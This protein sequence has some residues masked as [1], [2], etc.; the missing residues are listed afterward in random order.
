MNYNYARDRRNGS[1]LIII[2]L[3]LAPLLWNSGLMA[4]TGQTVTW[5][6]GNTFKS[7]MGTTNWT[8]GVVPINDVSMIFTVIVPDTTS[9]R[10]DPPAPATI[11]AFSFGAG[12]QLMVTNGQLLEVTGVAVLK[13]VI[14]ATGTN[15]GFKASANTIVLSS[16]PRL[17]ANSGGAIQLGGSTY[18]WDKYNANATLIS[19]M[20]GGSVVDL[21]SLSSM[22]LSYGDG[23]AW[24][25]GITAKTNGLIDL[26][27]LANL[28]GPGSD[29]VLEVNADTGGQVKLGSVRQVGSNVRFN[30]GVPIFDLPEVTTISSATFNLKTGMVM[31]LPKLTAL[32]G[33][34]IDVDSNSTINANLATSISSSSISL[35]TGT[36]FQAPQLTTM[37]GVPLT[38]NGNAAFVAPN[39]TSYRNS[40]IPVNPARDLEV[41]ILTNIYGSAITVSGGST[42]TIGALDYAMPAFG[43][44]TYPPKPMLSATGAG[45]FLN[46]GSLKSIQ[47]AGANYVWDPDINNWRYDFT[48][49][50][51]ADSQGTIDLSGTE[52]VYGGDLSNYGGDD[53]LTF[54]ILNGGNILLP[55]LKR[56]LRHTSFDVRVPQY[57]LPSLETNEN[58]G[59]TLADGVK[60]DVPS[61]TRFDN[62]Y[63][64]FGFNSTFNAPKLR[65]YLNSD[66]NLAPGKIFLAP[67]FTNFNA[68]RVSVTS[69]STLGVAAE[70]YETPPDWRWSPTLFSADGSGSRLNFAS[71]K[72]LRVYGGD[73]GGWT[74]SVNANN[75]GVVDLSGLQTVTGPDFGSYGND[76]WLSFTAQNGGK[77]LLDSLR[78]INGH[79]RITLGDGQRQ[80]LPSLTRLANGVVFNLGAGSVLAAPQLSEV[81]NTSLTLGGAGD[82]Q[83]GTLTN[84]YS[85]QLAATGGRTLRVTAEAY[86]T[87]ATGNYSYPPRVLFS[88]D[89]SGSVLDAAAMRSIQVYGA[90]YS[91]DPMINNWRY[92]FTYSVFAKNGGLVDFSG[93]SNVYG[94][95]P[96]AYSGGDD[97]LEFA[98]TTAGR[99]KFGTL[100]VE[101]RTRFSALDPDSTLEF[102]SL[103]LR[104]PATLTLGASTVL[105][106]RGDFLHEN[107]DTNSV[108]TEFATLVMDGTQPQDM[109]T[110]GAD[111]GPS[112]TSYRR[113]F[114]FSQLVVG[115]NSQSSIVKLVDTVNNGARGV[116]GAAESLYLYG[117]SGQGL[118]LLSGS[119]FILND[120]NCYAAVNSR[121]VDLKTLIPSGSNSV[122]FDGGYIGNFGGPAITNLTPSLAVIPP[123]SSVDVAFNIPIQASSFTVGDVVITGPSGAIAVTGVSQVGATTWRISFAS[124]TTSG[125]YN[126]KVGPSINEYAANFLGMDQDGDGLGG[127]GAGDTFTGSF[128]IDGTPP[129]VQSAYA[130]QGGSLVGIAFNEPVTSAFATNLANYSINGAA[131]TLAVLQ[132]NGM[133]VVLTVPALVGDSFAITLHNLEDLLGNKTERTLTGSILGLSAVD[134]GSPGTN[135]RERGSTVSFTGS[136]FQTVAGGSDFFW[137]GSD[138]GHFVYEGR[139]G[140]FDLRAQVTRLDKMPA[141]IYSQA[142]LMWRESLAANSRHAY[143]LVTPASGGNNHYAVTRP[144]T[145]VAGIEWPYSNPSARPGV[146]IPNAWV[147]LK[148]EGNVFIAFRGT[149]GVDWVE[150]ARLTNSFPADG[151]V[152]M[153]TSARNNNAGQATTAWY[154]NVSDFSPSIASQ[155]QSQTASSGKTVVFGVVARGLPALSYQ[156]FYNGQ[157]ISGQTASLLTL[158]SVTTGDV[159]DYRV[160]VTN[161]YGSVTSL[162]ATLV[163]DG[164]GLGGFEGDLS[165]SPNGNNA[166][167][168]ADW[169]KVGRLVAGL[170]TP[171]NT[172]EFVRA[173]CA[174]RMSGTNLVLG[175]GRLT[176]ADWTQSGRYAAALDPL[177]A[178]GG[179]TSGGSGAGAAVAGKDF[180]DRV[181]TAVA[182]RGWLGNEVE[183][184]I[185]MASQGDENALGFSLVFDPARLR[186]VGVALGKDAADAVLQNNLQSAPAGVVGVL[187]SRPVGLSFAAGLV[188]LARVRFAA[189]GGTGNAAVTF[190]DLPVYRE[191]V[192][193]TAEPLATG[194]VSGVVQ[195]VEAP[196]FTGVKPT[197]KG[198]I[199]LT[200]SGPAGILCTVQ[201]SSDLVN[202]EIMTTVLVGAEPVVVADPDAPSRAA[203]FYR[204]APK[205]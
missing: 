84:V 52:D 81:V 15:S 121:M 204:L 4:Q 32:T 88:A 162:A 165:P 185:R 101:R 163:V 157:P 108:G 34:T 186:C 73:G 142:G 145:G 54:R 30:L 99:M 154:D 147:R 177:T 131:P 28:T 110:G 137:N 87:P 176:V 93:L 104:P 25:Y 139:T 63:I 116:S 22:S 129:V 203:R 146:P 119:R 21:R 107:T 199:E 37:D 2:L 1:H 39:L 191:V 48:F 53:W 18:A 134:I 9:L 135:P 132:T 195:V 83:V 188:E 105:R 75:N 178:A 182:A 90:S 180:S 26:S 133:S 106:I 36:R 114:G 151:F 77:I 72:S 128:I 159:G 86:E 78:E 44:Y 192:N 33:S 5:S 17:Y 65:T 91:W 155:P 169:V 56:A 57:Q 196:R 130:L 174:P 152:G 160:T 184:P 166:V 41:G 173:D 38:L 140:D 3:G 117:L 118:R 11:E 85:S 97:W 24:T 31:N 55:N 60:L 95:H 13:G 125:V 112:T 175:D 49:L 14:T 124:Q 190:A 67:A 123:L 161:L 127:N 20:G 197:P 74:Y 120:L 80:D 144:T 164:V 109:E 102:G 181:V 96:T 149:N 16:N 89:G 58:S 148:R 82:L 113:N 66:L 103:Y 115:N 45:S 71:I 62:S 94:A 183:M 68:T 23:G 51:A 198:G 136:A 42:F 27:A 40:S 150:L 47:M 171:L 12:S 100:S 19:A 158:N 10:F 202:W 168:V 92:D 193:A 189:V 156:W 50:V 61:L 200:V 76:D 201:T 172:S 153:A 6:G 7:W 98:A 141:D 64:T 69:G 187:L 126:V 35:G 46:A 70:T 59:F 179:P 79:T 29:D 122:A 170:D 138:A 167:T 194:Y 43:N 205:Q 143:L 8:P 111:V